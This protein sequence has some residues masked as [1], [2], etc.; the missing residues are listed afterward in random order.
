MFQKL[1]IAFRFCIFVLWTQYWH[2]ERHW[3]F[4]CELLSDFVSS[5]F[6]HNYGYYIFVDKSVVNCF[7]ILYLRSLNTMWERLRMEKEK[8]W[9]AFRFC[10]FVLWTQFICVF[11]P[12]PWVVN[13]FQILYL[14]SLNTIG[15]TTTISSN[16]LWIAFRFCIFVL[17]TQSLPFQALHHPSCE[18]LSDFVSSFFEHNMLRWV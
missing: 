6:E 10:I 12:R 2:V 1:W 9:I 15:T 11:S 3:G 8:L 17:W 18:L 16:T 14:R 13:C 4:C 7:Q 5:F